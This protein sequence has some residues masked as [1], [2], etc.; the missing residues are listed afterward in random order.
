MPT[1]GYAA[2]PLPSDKGALG[3]DADLGQIIVD[4]PHQDG[5]DNDNIK[6]AD[7]PGQG[8]GP[9]IKLPFTADQARLKE[10][11]ADKFKAGSITT[12]VD[13]ISPVGGL[14]TGETRVLV[15]VG[16]MSSAGIRT[17]FKNM[18]LIFPQP[19]CKFGRND[20]IVKA[21]YVGCTESPLEF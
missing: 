18:N 6:D 21:Q 1:S 9:K 12:E 3:G 19:R 16:L 20:Q 4:K 17:S 5:D 7:Q 2:T 15:R 10:N 8:P 11:M 14:V 13:S